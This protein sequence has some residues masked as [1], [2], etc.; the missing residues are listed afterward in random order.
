VLK[1][2]ARSDSPLLLGR[3]AEILTPWRPGPCPITVEYS[4]SGAS[5]AL[6]LGAEWTVR[7]S[8]ELLEKL[9]GLVGRG[10]VQVVYGVPPAAAISSFAD[11]R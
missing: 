9:E 11:G 2:P 8:R 4:G 7:A 5:G 6:T 10:G 1:W 3:L